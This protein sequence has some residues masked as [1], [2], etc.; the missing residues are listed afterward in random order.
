MALLDVVA[1]SF[2]TRV[3]HH[4][5]LLLNSETMWAPPNFHDTINFAYL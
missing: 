2:G 1:I 5:M 4:Y 3:L